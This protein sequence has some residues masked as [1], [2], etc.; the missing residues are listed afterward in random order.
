MRR[1]TP[2][3]GIDRRT[4]AVE[5]PVGS[6]TVQEARWGV[7]PVWSGPGVVV[8]ALPEVWDVH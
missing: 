8:S 1:S 5:D 2:V 3:G 7:G 4:E 6:E